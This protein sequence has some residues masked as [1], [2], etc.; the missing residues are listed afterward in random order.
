MYWYIYWTNGVIQDPIAMT[1]EG[2]KIYSA[3]LP[4]G[5]LGSEMKYYISAEDDGGN[6]ANHPFIGEPDPHVFYVGEQLF[7]AISIDVAE[8]NAW[9]NQ[10]YI[11]V[12]EFTISSNEGELALNYNIDWSSAILENF[13]FDVDDSPAQNAWDYNTWTELSWTEME[14]SGIEG[15]IANW[16]N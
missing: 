10:G 9:A 4:A 14:V 15:E 3:T 6:L 5:I 8:I 16:S 12:E 1:Y 13:S 2:D 11:D 7:A